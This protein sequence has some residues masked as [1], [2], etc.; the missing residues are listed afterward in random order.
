MEYV[1]GD[2]IMHLSENLFL[3]NLRTSFVI[4][5]TIWCYY[6]FFSLFF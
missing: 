4:H 3:Q 1:D 2:S 5:E 6:P